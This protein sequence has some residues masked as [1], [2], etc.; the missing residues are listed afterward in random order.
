MSKNETK[1]INNT[2]YLQ[3]ERGTCSFCKG[4]CNILSQSC[5]FCARTLT[6]HFL[7]W[8]PLPDYILKNIRSDSFPELKNTTSED[9]KYEYAAKIEEN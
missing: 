7:G 3:Q 2:E 9:D 6:G 4:D 5:G 1:D 8:N